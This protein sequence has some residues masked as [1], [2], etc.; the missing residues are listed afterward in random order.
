MKKKK[1]VQAAGWATAHFA[2]GHNKVHCI[3]TQAHRARSKGH[4]TASSVPQ[5]DHSSATIRPRGPTIRQ[6]CAQGKR[7]AR[8]GLAAGSE[9]RDTKFCIVTEGRPGR[10]ACR[11][12]MLRHGQ[13]GTTIRP[14]SV[15]HGA[16]CARGM[17]WV[18]IQFCIVTGGKSQQCCYTVRQRARVCSDTTG[19][20][21]NTAGEGA[22]TQPNARHDTTPCARP[23]CCAR[24][25]WVQGV[26]PVH[27]TQS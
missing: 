17:D 24:A 10:W 16:Q 25:A 7:R 13:A 9:C 19:G 14:G 11:Y 23:G 1:K 27:P 22:T 20:A 4:D 8:E 26:H 6:A 5:D 21:C 3:V 12:T 15:R 18:A 2:L